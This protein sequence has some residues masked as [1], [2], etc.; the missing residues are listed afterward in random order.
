MVSITYRIN[1]H[2]WKT[3]ERF[4]LYIFP[5][6]TSVVSVI[7]LTKENWSIFTSSWI[8]L[9][10][11]TLRFTTGFK[12]ITSK[13]VSS[14]APLHWLMQ[15]GRHSI[16][17]WRCEHRENCLSVTFAIDGRV[18]RF[19]SLGILEA[20]LSVPPEIPQY[21]IA[22]MCGSFQGGTHLGPHGAGKR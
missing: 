21:Y 2:L 7:K 22:G 11:T 20:Q 12:R 16:D 3:S 15:W 1:S 8:K 5:L 10:I 18:E 17:Y 9:T 19:V 14:H 13:H 4:T 6:K